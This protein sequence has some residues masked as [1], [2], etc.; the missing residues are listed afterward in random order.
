MHFLKQDWYMHYKTGMLS[1]TS[2][3]KILLKKC[4]ILVTCK[5]N[6]KTELIET[7]VYQFVIKCSIPYRHVMLK[8][9]LAQIRVQRLHLQMNDKSLVS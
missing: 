9:L 5:I 2:D 8:M 4:T 6:V 1:C 3:K 7:T